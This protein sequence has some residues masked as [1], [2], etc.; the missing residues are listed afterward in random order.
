MTDAAARLGRAAGA[1][2]LSTLA[3]LTLHLAA[4]GHG[5]SAG[6]VL[7]C[8][9]AAF[10]LAAQL[11]GRPLGRARL[12]VIALASQLPFHLA[13]SAGANPVPSAAHPAATGH[14]HVGLGAG[15]ADVAGAAA[16][17]HDGAGMV[18]AHAGAALITYAVVRH[19]SRIADAARSVA[20][21]LAAALRAALVPASPATPPHRARPSIVPRG[22]APT[23]DGVRAARASRAPPAPALPL[24]A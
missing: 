18:L 12:A 5:A 3:A 4:G 24:P 23:R 17:A 22:A 20:D 14:H 9:A 11:A 1:A 2:G 16:A 15:M 21:L 19:A 6:A 7:A 10:A 13:F 8:F